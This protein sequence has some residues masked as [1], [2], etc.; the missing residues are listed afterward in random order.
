MTN[1]NQAPVVDAGRDQ[2]VRAGS[3][4]TLD[5]PAPSTP[6]VIACSRDGSRQ[7]ARR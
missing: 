5:G 6:T 7:Q 1:V 3:P 2:T 4:V